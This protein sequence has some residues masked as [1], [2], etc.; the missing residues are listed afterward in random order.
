MYRGESSKLDFA[1]GIARALDL[2]RVE[3]GAFDEEALERSTVRPEA[4]VI[5]DTEDD[6]D[7]LAVSRH[8][9]RPVGA[10]LVDEAAELLLRVLKLPAGQAMSFLSRLDR[11]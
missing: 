4:P 2:E 8:D 3:V 6:G 10:S 7:L 11:F 5:L 1:C 9:L